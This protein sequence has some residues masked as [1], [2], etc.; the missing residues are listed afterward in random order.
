[1]TTAARL[2]ESAAQEIEA[3]QSR[4][5]ALM[6][7][8]GWSAVL[9]RRHENIAW[10]TA[11][12]VEARVALGVE[13]AVCSLLITRQGKR[14]YIAPENEGPRLAAEEFAGLGFEPILYPWIQDALADRAHQAGGAEI[15]SDTGIPGFYPANFTSLRTPL[16]PSE[17]DRFRRLAAEVAESTV[18]VLK[19]FAPGITE[20]EM[21]ARISADLLARH[22]TPSVLLMGTDERILRFKHA[23]PRAGVLKNYGMLNLCARRDGMVISITRFVHFGP[24][25]AT[26]AA[27]FEKAARINA[28]LL[29]ATRAGATAAS[30]YAVAAE[31]YAEAGFP[32]E[33]TKHHQGGACG[34]A[35]RDWVAT[36]SGTQRVDAVQGFAWNPSLQGAKAEDTVLLNNGE[37]EILT[38]T[39]DLPVIET[40]LGGKVYRSPGVF[41]P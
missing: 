21:A 39:P 4:L 13:T 40:K 38:A 22:I 26:L 31:G 14:Y 5:A 16:L 24:M 12:R 9:L 17:V 28:D 8:N 37:I 1:M 23:V 34:Y 2:P 3:K 19:S 41:L 7:E 15:G 10:A 6:D 32:D 11:G 20:N 18:R 36:P 29:H 30:L 35:E 27:N 25:P 33:I